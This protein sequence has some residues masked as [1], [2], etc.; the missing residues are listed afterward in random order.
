MEHLVQLTS[1][2][3][4]IR[5]SLMRLSGSGMLDVLLHQKQHT[6]Y[7]VFF[8]SDVFTCPLAY[9]TFNRDAYGGI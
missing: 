3:M 7:M 9:N 8:V 5:L 4:V 1:L 2:I 6:D